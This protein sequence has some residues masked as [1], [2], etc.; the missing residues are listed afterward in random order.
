MKMD[1]GVYWKIRS[2]A[3]LNHIIKSIKRYLC[4]EDIKNDE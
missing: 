1:K 3:E 2:Q 4:G